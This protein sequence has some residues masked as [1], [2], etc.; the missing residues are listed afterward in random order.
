MLSWLASLCYRRRGW[1]VLAWMLATGVLIFFGVR[2]LAPWDNSFGG[3]KTESEQAQQLIQQ[4]FPH[5]TGDS[6][7]LAIQAQAG[8]DDPS[9]RSHQPLNTKSRL[10]RPGWV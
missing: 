5:R 6:L 3:G 8:L 4:H 9:V 7:T 2:Y 1:V 10:V